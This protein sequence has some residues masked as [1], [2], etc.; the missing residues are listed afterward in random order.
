MSNTW[1]FLLLCAFAS[2]ETFVLKDVHGRGKKDTPNDLIEEL[3]KWIKGMNSQMNALSTRVN[4]SISNMQ[5][6]I[7]SEAKKISDIKSTL[8]ASI[9]DVKSKLQNSVRAVNSSFHNV[10]D[11]MEAQLK[12]VKESLNEDIVGNT[13]GTCAQSGIN[14]P[15]N[16]IKKV[17][18]TSWQDCSQECRALPEC[19]GWTWNKLNNCYLKNSSW[20]TTRREESGVVSGSRNCRD[21]HKLHP[22]YLS[23]GVKFIGR[24]IP[25]ASGSVAPHICKDVDSLDSCFNWCVEMRKQRSIYNGV[26]YYKPG[27]HCECYEKADALKVATDHVY[28][29]FV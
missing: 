10:I 21:L 7:N 12:S 4:V 15:Q 25:Y 2:Y 18:A 26:L 14:Y 6:Q 1:L 27:R 22:Y 5:K 11:N 20:A 17:K 3:T 24:Y 13:K 8:E 16:D 29:L 19:Y 28:Y 23:Y 9:A